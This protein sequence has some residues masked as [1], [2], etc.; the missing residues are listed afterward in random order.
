MFD[1]ADAPVLTGDHREEPAISGADAALVARARD[2][3]REVGAGAFSLLLAI[4]AHDRSRLAPVFDGS[5]PGLSSLSR[6]LSSPSAARFAHA[7]MSGVTPT[8]WSAL[9]TDPISTL[10]QLAWA[11]RTEPPRDVGPEGVA[12]PV[13]SECGR[14]GALVFEGAVPDLR[15]VDLCGIHCRAIALFADVARQRPRAAGDLP[16]MSR[17]ELECL[18][19][20]ANGLTSDAIAT[21]LGLSVHTANQYLTNSTQK[22]NAV[23]RIHAVAKALRLGLID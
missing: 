10:G 1:E 6:G 7:L 14:S 9:A 16:A 12:F 18:K 17:R 13:S 23:N 2:L 5:H 4:S 3:A 11:R 15:E 21:R 19:L 22:L 8:W 20:T